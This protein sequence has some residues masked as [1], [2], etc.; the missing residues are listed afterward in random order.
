MSDTHPH[1]GPC[2]C[3]N[4]KETKVAEYT[5]HRILCVICGSHTRKGTM[6]EITTLWNEGIKD[7]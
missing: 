6:D 5:V 7:E 3:C 1:I 4:S 2:P